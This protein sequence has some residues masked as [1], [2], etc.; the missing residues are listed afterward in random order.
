MSIAINS[1]PATFPLTNKPIYSVTTTLVESSSYQNIRIRCSVYVDGAIAFVMEQPKGL[2][3]FDLKSM[4]ASMC[5]KFMASYKSSTKVFQPFSAWT[6]IYSGAWVNVSG[7]TSFTSTGET[8]LVASKSSGG[9]GSLCWTRTPAITGLAL[10]D[11]V[12]ILLNESTNWGDA[13][14]GTNFPKIRLTKSTTVDTD[15]VDEISP[16]SSDGVS[17]MYYLQVTEDLSAVNAYIWVGG[18]NSG[19]YAYNCTMYPSTFKI[20]VSQA[21]LYGRPCVYFKAI[22]QTYYED[23]TFVTQTPAGELIGA[24]MMMFAPVTGITDT[25]FSTN[26]IAKSSGYSSRYF[27]SKSIG[28]YNQAKNYYYHKDNCR[29]R[30]MGISAAAKQARLKYKVD[31]AGSYTTYDF[32]HA[33]WF[34]INLEPE[35]VSGTAASKVE[36]LLECPFGTPITAQHE[37]EFSVKNWLNQIHLNFKGRLGDEVVVLRGIY[38]KENFIKKETYV[39]GYKM[40]LPL[41][42]YPL[43]KIAIGTGDQKEAWFELL[44]EMLASTKTI[45]MFVTVNTNYGYDYQI[46]VSIADTNVLINDN[47]N[48]INNTIDLTYWE[49]KE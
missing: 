47:D 25:E 40:E 23:A 2:P 35:A 11:V 36:I 7:W 10:G 22:F 6:N 24:P 13:G 31:G 37:I 1:Y 20:S 30:I 45:L 3:L 34:V 19:T 21:A 26:Y 28:L 27:L 39:N 43:K 12:V 41:N 16:N 48:I 14:Q 18:Y 15:I 4:L 8:S 5:G 44:S 49:Y 46:P 38:K 33:G 42:T 29:L 9:G 32:Y 17:S